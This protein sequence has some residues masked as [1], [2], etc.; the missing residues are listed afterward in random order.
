MKMKFVLVCTV[1]IVLFHMIKLTKISLGTGH[2]L[3]SYN[4]TLGK[5]KL[6]LDLR[7]PDEGRQFLFCFLSLLISLYCLSF[8]KPASFTQLEIWL[9]SFQAHSFISREGLKLDCQGKNSPWEEFYQVRCYSL[10]Q[11][12]AAR[13]MKYDDQFNKPIQAAIIVVK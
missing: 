13:K 1:R 4:Q 2:F 5:G 3:F 8:L 9:S 6:Q 10:G 12:A 7:S 11:S